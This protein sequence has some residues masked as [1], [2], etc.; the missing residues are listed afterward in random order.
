MAAYPPL[1]IGCGVASER[2]ASHSAGWMSSAPPSVFGLFRS[3]DDLVAF[4]AFIGLVKSDILPARDGF[5]AFGIP[6]AYGYFVRAFAR[7]ENARER[8]GCATAS[9]A[10]DTWW[11]SSTRTSST[12]TSGG[13]RRRCVVPSSAR[14]V[15]VVQSHMPTMAF[16]FSGFQ[17]VVSASSTELSNAMRRK[18]F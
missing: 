1:Q 6:G 8:A 2:N 18:P 10:T 11:E 17:L 3:Q 7:F 4:R 16:K 5:R 9:S 14:G 13:E 12:S 15:R